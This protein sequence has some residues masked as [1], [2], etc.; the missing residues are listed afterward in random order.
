MATTLRATTVPPT[1]R[2]EALEYRLILAASFP[3]FLAAAVVA[4]L[5]PSGR[6]HRPAAGPRSI[7]GEARAAARTFVPFAFM[8]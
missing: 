3:V 2:E 8:A 6:R 5:L 4:R 7:I 1:R